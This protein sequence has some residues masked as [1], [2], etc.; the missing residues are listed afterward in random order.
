M[1]SVLS[2]TEGKDNFSRLCRLL[3]DG[4][5]KA[6]LTVFNSI[7]P[8][9]SLAKSLKKNKATLKKLLNKKVIRQ[10]QWDLLFPPSGSLP[11][12]K[13]YDIT[14]L[15]CLLRNICS[16]K[17]PSTTSGWDDL[18]P[19]T[20]TTMEANMCRLKWHGNKMFAHVKSTELKEGDFLQYWSEISKA[21]VDLG[22]VT[23]GE[24]DALKDAPLGEECKNVLE[25]WYYHDLELAK[26]VSELRVTTAKEFSKLS[27]TTE[28]MSEDIQHSMSSTSKEVSML[29]ATTEKIAGDVQDIKRSIQGQSSSGHVANISNVT[30]KECATSA[31]ADNAAVSN[32]ASASVEKP[33][34]RPKVIENLIKCLREKYTTGEN[35]LIEPLDNLHGNDFGGIRYDFHLNKMFSELKL[36][37]R[38][39]CSD[40]KMDGLFVVDGQLK[41]ACRVLIEGESGAGKTTLCQ[42]LAFD[43]AKGELPTS[44]SFPE[45]E[46][47][48]FLRCKEMKDGGIAK[49]MQEQLLSSET[50]DEERKQVFDYMKENQS[51]ILMI[52]DGYDELPVEASNVKERLGAVITRKAFATSNVLVTIRSQEARPEQISQGYNLYKHFVGG[53]VLHL[54]G[55]CDVQDYIRKL[56]P[57]DQFLFRISLQGICNF[58]F[59]NPLTLALYCLCFQ[60]HSQTNA[61]K[62]FEK[63]ISLR[64]LYDEVVYLRTRR[65]C[66]KENRSLN[67]DE[68]RALHLELGKIAFD[69][70]KENAVTFR[71][72]KP[73][74]DLMK[75]GFLRKEKPSS[76]I[77][78]VFLYSFNHKSFQDYFCA[79]YLASRLAQGI[80]DPELLRNETFFYTA[81]MYDLAVMIGGNARKA[82]EALAPL[83]PE[84]SSLGVPICDWH[85]HCL[86][87][88]LLCDCLAECEDIES[89]WLQE[90]YQRLPCRVA[91]DV[92]HSSTLIGLSHLLSRDSSE[93]LS[94]QTDRSASGAPPLSHLTILIDKEGTTIPQ[95]LVDAMAS[96]SSLL[97]LNLVIRK[98]SENTESSIDDL[99][100]RNSSIRSFLFGSSDKYT[101]W[102]RLVKSLKDNSTLSTFHIHSPSIDDNCA[103][104]LAEVLSGNTTLTDIYIGGEILGDAG[105][106]YI[107]EAL[108]FNTTIRT[109]AINPGRVTPDAGQAFGEMLRHNN[110][111][112]RLT[113]IHSHGNIVDLGAQRI[114]DGLALNTKVTELTLVNAGIGPSGTRALA[115]AIQN[116][117][118]L[119]MS[120]NPIGLEGLNAIAN[121]LQDNS[122]RL[123]SLILDGCCINMDGAR[124][125]SKAL[126]KNT[127]LEKLSLACN[128]IG[129]EGMCAL[130]K[131]V[132]KT[133]S[134]QALDIS[135]NHISDVGKK[136]IIDACSESE[137]L[138]HLF[139]ESDPI[140]NSC[141]KPHSLSICIRDKLFRQKTTEKLG[142]P[143]HNP[144]KRYHRGVECKVGVFS[145]AVTL[146]IG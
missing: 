39:T 65:F 7:H 8:P 6:L 103:I 58:D 29:S 40:V 138:Q 9:S 42:K 118:L 136:A 120:A 49:A 122:C 59:S 12:A 94:P 87:F 27:A 51:K 114:S 17:P 143:V 139:H 22:G 80:V 119:D 93:I 57:L 111:I 63:D 92:D 133:K 4:G 123:K 2:G 62:T 131:Y 86:P 104:A 102:V 117:T 34:T 106:Q 13:N 72:C 48:L 43:W 33:H 32:T 68:I 132:T 76:A 85:E 145:L 67:E 46:L 60:E 134:L 126:S 82:I 100:S 108:K 88:S 15:F 105:V 5:T 89:S 52:L 129:D 31:V 69:S 109:L 142:F 144:Y 26:E 3:V 112:T 127:S 11:D 78:P 141:S 115:K 70:L 54:K 28:K 99:L 74:E 137:S 79:L 81:T 45:V 135:Y 53:N 47:L 30:L 38:D 116:V 56:F 75:I 36:V 146:E 101:T 18:P 124:S 37:N 19:L 121:I 25:D 35:A 16:L 125:I 90:V 128:N 44:E 83:V 77:R 113:S 23:E 84:M 61:N 41:E 20:D 107:A 73:S 24:V 21:I 10:E 66:E 130:A 55:L 96:S 95:Q 14:L 110:T 97:T 50:S 98:S 64:Q 140:L 1:A 71:L 91:A